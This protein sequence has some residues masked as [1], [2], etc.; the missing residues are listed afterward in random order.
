[1]REKPYDNEVAPSGQSDNGSMP[2][3]ETTPAR[4]AII[5][6]GSLALVSL[7]SAQQTP[8]QRSPEMARLLSAAAHSG[9]PYRTLADLTETIGPRLTGSPQ[10]ERATQWAVEQM[11]R[12]GLQSVHTEPWRLSSSWRRGFAH[13]QLLEPF[14]MPLTVTSYGWTGSTRPEG[15]VAELA[16]VPGDIGREQLDREATGW[17]GK[18]VF[19]RGA[20]FASLPILV[21]AAERRRAVA[22]ISRDSR[23]GDMLHTG[24]VGFG[25]RPFHIPVLDISA[26]QEHLLDT[27]IGRGTGVRLAITVRNEIVDTP[28]D[29][30]NVVGDIPGTNRAEEMV[31]VAAHLDSWDLGTGAVDDG[32]GVAAVLAAAQA[33]HGAGLMPRRTIR[34]VLFTG[35]EQGL[36]GSRAY[37]SAH[38]DAL[39]HL[40]C[41]FAVDWGKGPISGL[42]LA[43]H[44]ELAA[45][46][47]ELASQLE[48]VGPI[49]VRNGYLTFTDAYA[50]SLAGAPGLAFAQQADDYARLAHSAADTLD[51]VD[52]N[53]LDRMA[54][55]VAASAFWVADHPERLGQVWSRA[56]TARVLEQDGQ[57]ALLQSLHLWPF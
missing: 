56:D 8:A 52:P 12:A 53:V 1:M 13:A 28:S 47:R 46:L 16:A 40:V 44:R 35:E 27:L 50:F 3:K 20:P 33:I 37:V 43:G 25:D 4:F 9:A 2:T 42:A 36:L 57:R 49:A 6:L 21:R 24:P 48:E 14:V 7:V 19:F 22:V 26:E 11:S 10:A 45:P 29:S 38:G 41:A 17:A 51:K 30:W 54:A 23:P 32:V 55:V 18:I 34:F 15:V 39:S 5:A 31:I